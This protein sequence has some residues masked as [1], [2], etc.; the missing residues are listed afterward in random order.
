MTMVGKYIA[1]CGVIDPKEE[2]DAGKKYEH[3][4]RLL[5]PGGGNSLG[6]A[7]MLCIDQ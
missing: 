2:G 4:K 7:K 5:P 3:E 1:F 6:R